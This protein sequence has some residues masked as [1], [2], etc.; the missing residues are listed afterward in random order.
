MSGIIVLI[1]RILLALALYGFLGWAFYSIWRDM[2]INA[3]KVLTEKPP[4]LTLRIDDENVKT[5][6][7]LEFTIGRDE[8]ND[9]ILSD[10]TVSSFHAKIRFHHKQWWV[11]DMQST[12]GT[13]LNEERIYTPTILVNEDDIILGK[14]VLNVKIE[15]KSR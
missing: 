11:E 15:D 4:K 8:S 14:I 3:K 12:N 7:L 6:N 5:F 9:L 13:F 10:E 2:Q 1:F